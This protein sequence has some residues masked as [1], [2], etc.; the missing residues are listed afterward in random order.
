MNTNRKALSLIEGLDKGLDN[1][2]DSALDKG[3]DNALDKGLDN[4]E[5]GD[6]FVPSRKSIYI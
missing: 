2:L 6:I 5:K 1:A 4:S 3:L